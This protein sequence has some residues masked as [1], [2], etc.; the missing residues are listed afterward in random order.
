M[1]AGMSIAPAPQ[2]ENFEVIPPP[3][4]VPW[5]EYRRVCDERDQLEQELSW[6][7]HQIDRLNERLR[8]RQQE[9]EWRRGWRGVS[10]KALSSTDKLV[11]EDLY[12]VNRGRERHGHDQGKPLYMEGRAAKLGTTGRAYGSSVQRL[13]A[14]DLIERTEWRDPKSGKRRVSA[15]AKEAFWRPEQFKAPAELERKYAFHAPH[16]P[17]HPDAAVV[18]KTTT[19]RIQVTRET[20]THDYICGDCG[21]IVGH[22]EESYDL[23]TVTLSSE[24]KQHVLPPAWPP[25][26]TETQLTTCSIELENTEG[27]EEQGAALAIGDPT[28]NLLVGSDDVA[29]VVPIET[30]PVPAWIPLQLESVPAELCAIARWYISRPEYRSGKV[31][32]AGKWTKPPR[33]ARTGDLADVTDPTTGAPFELIPGAMKRYG[34]PL[35]GL[36]LSD[37]DDVLAL[38]IDGCR[39]PETGAI[40]LRP[41]AI[42]RE[43][44]TYWEPSPSGTGLRMFGR[45]ALP[46]GAGNIWHIDGLKV[47]VYERDRYVTVTGCRLGGTSSR[48]ADV[49]DQL[50]ALYARRDRPPAPLIAETPR[51]PAPA[52][53]DDAELIRRA[54]GARHGVPFEPLWRGDLRDVDGDPSRGDYRLCRHLAFWTRG[55]RARVDRLWRASGLAVDPERVAKWD[56]VHSGDG[57]TY[58]QMTTDRAIADAGQGRS[59]A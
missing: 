20:I 41:L 17:D 22:T 21:T 6:R 28:N 42:V 44:G 56:S 53:E 59:N 10:T 50:A 27:G 1:G 39:D 36:A 15:R 9:A 18:E 34:V 35:A 5:Q 4:V 14:L 37:A 2:P 38:D 51:P 13:H 26:S 3:A 31:G 25:R 33:S 46:P 8:E 47:E 49:T 52:A 24:T 43:L 40:D 19:Q 55:D 57:R 54:C 16:C 23:E 58:G 12:A 32:K 29:E 30:P 48:L 11:L 7:R 45:G